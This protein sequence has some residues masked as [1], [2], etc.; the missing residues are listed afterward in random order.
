MEDVLPGARRRFLTVRREDAGHVGRPQLSRAGGLQQGDRERHLVAKLR[1]AQ[2]A[3][4]GA[5]AVLASGGELGLGAAAVLRP[6][7]ARP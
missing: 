5:V 2:H 4:D 6:P 1:L 7:D 3:V